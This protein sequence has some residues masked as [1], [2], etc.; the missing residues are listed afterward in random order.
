[1]TRFIRLRIAALGLLTMAVAGVTILR[2]D[3]PH[4]F[5][6]K[7]ARI[8]TVAGTPIAS[9]TIV[10]RNGLI[11]AVG[12]DVAVPSTATVIEGAGLTVYPGLID[13]GTSTGVEVP[14]PTPPTFRT[15]AEAERFRRSTN[16]RPDLDAASHLRA[17]SPEL[18]RFA[19]AGITS[20]LATPP[21]GI[22]KGQSALVNVAG[23]V[24]ERPQIG[25]VGDYREGL[26]VVRTPVALHVD[27][28]GGG[29]RGGGYPVSLMGVISFVRQHFID[30]RY[31][32]ALQERY[33]KAANTG[34]PRPNYDASLN[35]LQPALDGKLP[36]AFE[37]NAAR[38][39][40]RVLEMAR[41]F[42]L[43]P[44]VTGAGEAND[45]AEDLKGRNVRVI[46][47]VNYPTR[48]RSL[49]PDADEPL[50]VLRAR[51][52]APKVPAALQKAG[53]TFA[54]SS[55][56][57]RDPRDFVRNVA[58]AVRKGLPADA[59][60]RALTADAAKIAGAADRLGTLEKGRIANLLVTEGDIFDNAMKVKHVF[61]DGRMVNVEEAPPQTGGR[62]GRGGQ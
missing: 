58:R 40:L 47:N 27:Y 9:G 53:V 62:G 42:K 22:F 7:G 5:A 45:V 31:Q 49:P 25:D 16:F 24:T 15:T 28:G 29:G 46:Y 61:V 39:I 26:Q 18:T 3:V 8:V 50:S 17:D 43:D 51:A 19:S 12:A 57:L 44:I 54:F 20:V 2:A 23:S 11:D 48:S 6:I 55:A 35:A 36:V 59:A 41:E 30:A 52:N 21:N 38:E 33:A 1:M 10:V 4:V 37:A 13:M 14:T 32:R 34:T 60:L 56:G